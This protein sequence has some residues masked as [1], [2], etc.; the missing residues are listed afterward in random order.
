[1]GCA[2]E[3]LHRPRRAGRMMR[4]A[5]IDTALGTFGLAWTHTGVARVALPGSDRRRTEMWISR[6]PA[7]PGFPE[8]LLAD[9]PERIRRYAEGEQID[10]SN[11]PLDLTGLADFNVACY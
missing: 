5:L 7:E 3:P 4:Y 9:L 2:Q 8:G 6:D 1:H 11:V 10:F